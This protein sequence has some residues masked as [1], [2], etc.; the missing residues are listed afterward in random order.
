MKKPLLLL[1]A[2]FLVI[3]TAMYSSAQNA[4]TG[5]KL[6]KDLDEYITVV[7]QQ[8]HIPGLALALIKDGKVIHRKCYGVANVEYNIPLND[9]IVFPLFSTTKVFSVVAAYQLIEQ[10]K[11]SLDSK[12]TEFIA[13]LPDTWKAIKIE[14]LLTHS[15]GLP[16]IVD[17]ETEREESVAKAKV[18]KD[19][20]KFQPGNQFDYNQTNFWLLNRVIQ[21]ITGKTLAQYIIENQFSSFKNSAV[22]EG[23]NLRVVKNLSYG[24]LYENEQTMLKRNWFFPEYM[25]GTAGLNLSLNDFINWNKQFD[26]GLLIKESTKQQA[27]K[28]YH[29]QQERDFTYGFDLIKTDGEI[30]YGFSGGLATAFRKFPA[31]KITVIFLANGM[32]IPAGKLRGINEVINQI[33]KI[34]SQ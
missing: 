4:V 28:P 6:N 20:I 15:S 9:Q 34:G 16:D 2:L 24:Y 7:Q 29:Y 25:Y 5:T 3:S 33:E 22:F 14:N 27:L 12:I 26:E 11:F 13:D 18:Y 8:Y 19:A 23:N 30:S 1:M 31:S 17:Y 32:L 21:K 10:K